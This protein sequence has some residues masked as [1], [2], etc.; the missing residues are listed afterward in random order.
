MKRFAHLR[1]LALILLV[2]LLVS[3][4]AMPAFA[5]SQEPVR[6][7][8]DF[9][10]AVNAEWLENTILSPDRASISGFSELAQ[11]VYARLLADFHEMC[12][13]ETPGA[14]GQFLAYWAL[15]KDLDTRNAQGADPLLPVIARIT[16]LESISQLCTIL[17]EWV[18]DSMPLPFSLAVAPDM[19]NARYYAL[20]ADGP[21]LFLPDASYYHDPFGAVLLDVFAETGI[22][23][24]EMAQIA[25][26]ATIIQ[27][28]LAFDRLLA[29]YGKS[30]A[31][32]AAYTALYN[33][34]D[35]DTFASLG[36][37]LDFDRLIQSLV[38]QRPAQVI[39]MNPDYFAALPNLLSEAHFELLRDW[40]LTRAVFDLAGF[41][42]QAF[43]HTAG[44]FTDAITGQSGRRDPADLAFLLAI[45]IFGG[46]VGKHYGQTYFGATAKAEVSAMADD[47]I[48]AFRQRLLANDWL[49]PET[50]AAAL[51]KLDALTV[52]IGYPDETPL[53]YDRFI[54]TDTVDGGTL[55]G[56]TLAF[57]R[58][59]REENFAR[60]GTT[61]DR[62]A[63]SMSGHTVNA[64]YNPLANAIT[65]PAAILQAPFY[66]P[67]QSMSANLGGIGAVIAHEIT[68][69]F[70][71]SGSQFGADGSLS[72]WW[73][74]ADY[75]AFSTRAQA[76][77]ELFDGVCHAGSAV[78]GR[79]T[80][81]EN[82]ADAGGLATALDVLESL[83]DGN[84]EE[85]FRN[86]AAI[87]RNVST[88]EYAQ[89]LLT[90][91]VHAPGKLRANLQLGN[92]NV[93][94][95]TFGV[96]A[97]DAMYIDPARRVTIW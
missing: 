26:P 60:F 58:M 74:A 16:D 77:I 81:S 31:E 47:L 53:I 57:A 80:V 37:D 85:F 28:A 44:R 22:A 32:T 94:Y 11:T 71:L 67:E 9:Y 34:V 29:P 82:I 87:W 20:Y 2:I 41:L 39:V 97:E 42:D 95:D 83:P 18:L 90:M 79:L 64:Q 6:L 17:D 50:I 89:L 40:M 76:M 7:E 68:H 84:P 92:L 93:F 38:D 46:V 25:D 13:R 45:E 75:G 91:D 21:S 12:P 10:A 72:D 19:G 69:A 35:M 66:S 49:S 62:T 73:T 3:G 14:L 61:V 70:D 63:W 27:N 52:H 51:T 15:A 36:G 30:A 59:A 1:A 4:T 5:V 96:T 24:L 33:P 78:C 23:L 86:W 48:H 88:P 54:V 43:L 8:D 56:N 55:L 65:F